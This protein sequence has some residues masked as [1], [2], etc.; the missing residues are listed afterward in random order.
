MDQRKATTTRIYSATEL[1]LVGNKTR[2]LLW[3]R[4]L[5][6]SYGYENGLKCFPRTLGKIKKSFLNVYLREWQDLWRCL[7]QDALEM[8]L[9]DG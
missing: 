3:K 6:E 5:R 1:N 7:Y 4:A 8:D 9:H 2:N